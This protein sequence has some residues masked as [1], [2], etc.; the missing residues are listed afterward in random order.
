MA[1]LTGQ[2]GPESA[3]GKGRKGEGKGRGPGD[4]SGH[5]DWGQIEVSEDEIATLVR[6]F[7]T[8]ARADGVLAPVFARTVNDWDHHLV[9]VQDF[10]SH[11][12]LGTSRYKGH[13]FPVHMHLPIEPEHFDRWL[14][15][16]LAAADET[17]PDKAAARAKARAV[18]MA[19]SFRV[20]LF[21]F[22]GADG[23]PSRL[24]PQAAKAS[25]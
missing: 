9:L 6:V 13:P 11:V 15:L 21:P 22:T 14:E 10:W 4:G 16:F 25:V 20:G 24:P 12:L 3:T 17:L 23:R 5:R 8:N 2:E 18:H 1:N 19:E 7:Y